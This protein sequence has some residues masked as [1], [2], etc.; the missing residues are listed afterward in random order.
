MPELPQPLLRM[1]ELPQPPELELPQLPA[2]ELLTAVPRRP[3][4]PA[5]QPITHRGPAPRRLATHSFT[6]TRRIDMGAM[7]RLILW[8]LT[9]RGGSS[10]IAFWLTLLYS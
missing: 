2:P 4:E 8:P 5:R 3:V 10:P 6:S 9:C 7:L 1:L